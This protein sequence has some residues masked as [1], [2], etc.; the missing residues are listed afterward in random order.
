VK[1][2][3][4]PKAKVTLCEDKT[5]NSLITIFNNLTAVSWIFK[6]SFFRLTNQPKTLIFKFSAD[7]Q[8][9]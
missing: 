7:R 1:N 2:E 4:F 6:K 9:V 5:G 8:A 3:R